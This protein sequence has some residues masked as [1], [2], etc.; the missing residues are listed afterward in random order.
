[1]KI[2]LYGPVG[3]MHL[4]LHG[5]LSKFLDST[6]GD[7]CV[8]GYIFVKFSNYLFVLATAAS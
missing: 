2:I 3:C 7:Q 1:M 4:S 8:K 6:F 5:S